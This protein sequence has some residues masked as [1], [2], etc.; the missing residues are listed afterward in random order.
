VTA[1]RI[2]N[3]ELLSAIFAKMDVV[4]LSLS[5]G[6]LCGMALFGATAVLL[7]QPTPEN[8][9][10][11][12]HLGALADYLPGYSVS[13]LGALVGSGYGLVIGASLGFFVALHWNLAHY[14]AIGLLLLR[15]AELAD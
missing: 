6:V 15:S 12:P 3:H 4:G 9:P 8:L 14:L 7:L 11:G 2:G 1:R 5:M 10:I 13:W